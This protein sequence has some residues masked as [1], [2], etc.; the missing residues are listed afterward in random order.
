MGVRTK[1]RRRI[2]VGD[3]LF[4]WY[5]CEDYDS[6]DM[7]LQVVSEDKKFIVRYHLGQADD[8]FLIVIGAEFT[9]VP[10][11]GG[12]WRRFLCPRW[13][14]NSKVTPASVRSLIEW[15]LSSDKP[16]R[17]VDWRGHRTAN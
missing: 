10:D 11:A 5:V 8:P 9:G 2:R 6:P 4:I 3:R 7:V 1:W 13:E 12:I 17:E 14:S 16:L 15:C